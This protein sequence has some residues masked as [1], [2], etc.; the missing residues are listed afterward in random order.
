MSRGLRDAAVDTLVRWRTDAIAF[1]RECCGAEPDPFQLEALAAFPTSS[2]LAVVGSKGCGK[3]AL[4]AW[5]I[6]CFLLTRP[7]ANIA[8]TSISGD[9]LKDGL[10][11]ELALWIE[12]SPILSA[13]FE[14]QSSR[15]VSRT[16]PATW[17][18]SARQ[19]SKS[20][21]AQQ[22]SQTLAGLH[23]DYTLFV[24]DEAG[25]V[26]QAVAVTAQAAL[27]SV[28]ECKLVIA[29]NPT[30]LEGP[31]YSAAVTHRQHWHV[32]TATGDP[33]DPK[34]ATRVDLTWAKQQLEMFGSEN[35]WCRVKA[36]ST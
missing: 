12:R 29:G 8:V 26:P 30:S 11:K 16:H 23:A 34:R 35:P 27:A 6:L 20:A 3:T 2:Q 33:D 17:W 7:L 31:L 36:L 32:V 25:S 14:W 13:A 24:I 19:W 18:V 5:E 21:D 22:Q 9:N 1:V 28:K 10:W 15:I 4:L